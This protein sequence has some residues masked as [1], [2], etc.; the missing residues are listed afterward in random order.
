MPPQ[1]GVITPIAAVGTHAW[2]RVGVLAASALSKKPFRHDEFRPRGASGECFGALRKHT[3]DSLRREDKGVLAV[4]GASKDCRDVLVAAPEEALRQELDPSGSPFCETLFGPRLRAGTGSDAGG[5]GAGNCWGSGTS[6]T[7]LASRTCTRR[8]DTGRLDD[9]GSA[10]KKVA[11]DLDAISKASS[12][13]AS[14]NI[15]AVILL[16]PG[17]WASGVDAMDS[18]CE[19]PNDRLTSSFNSRIIR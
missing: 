19:D 10:G 15:S 5:G 17:E 12:L 7:G 16:D 4:P 6:G 14:S 8:E 11:S 13:N 1:P 3:V 9:F 2:R 18:T